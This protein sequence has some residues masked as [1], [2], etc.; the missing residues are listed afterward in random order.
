M[1]TAE[2]IDKARRMVFSFPTDEELQRSQILSHT[3]YANNPLPSETQPI[4]NE[5]ERRSC[6]KR[7]TNA[8]QHQSPGVADSLT[9]LTEGENEHRPPLKKGVSKTDVSSTLLLYKRLERIT[10]EDKHWDKLT[11]RAAFRILAD[12]NSI[13][14]TP[15]IKHNGDV[16]VI[17]TSEQIDK[18]R[19]TIF[20][21][22]TDEELHRSQ[23]LSQTESVNNPLASEMEQQ[24]VVNEKGRLSYTKPVVVQHQKANCEHYERHSKEHQ[25]LGRSV[26]DLQSYLSERMN[27][28]AAG[29]IRG[30]SEADVSRRGTTNQMAEMESRVQSSRMQLSLKQT[31]HKK[32]EFKRSIS[33][34]SLGE[35]SETAAMDVKKTQTAEVFVDVQPPDLQNKRSKSEWAVAAPTNTETYWQRTSKADNDPS[36]TP[37][38]YRSELYLRRVT[39][40]ESQHASPESADM[41]PVINS[42]NMTG[43]L[44]GRNDLSVSTRPKEQF[45]SRPSPANYPLNI[46]GQSDLSGISQAAGG[47][48]HHNQGQTVESDTSDPHNSMPGST[49]DTAYVCDSLSLE[50]QSGYQV[51]KCAAASQASAMKDARLAKTHI[52]RQPKG[53]NISSSEKKSQHLNGYAG[54]GT[55]TITCRFSSGTLKVCTSTFRLKNP[56]LILSEEHPISVNQVFTISFPKT[57]C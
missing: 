48:R 56:V 8:A 41:S 13:G 55:I 7:M 25:P 47:K 18:A 46:I 28:Q 49:L 42:T 29:L 33:V 53:G 14:L 16:T 44:S 40:D 34:L 36:T 9:R 30:A 51:Q 6:G 11:R 54:C 17:G 50:S 4:I 26:A 38:R 12:V 3:E 20:S 32:P 24:P 37:Q 52:A 45:K 31:C 43:G 35:P 39:A 19:R 57:P 21:F 15:K 10:I 27:Q 5:K 22:P 1:G 23:I 2:R